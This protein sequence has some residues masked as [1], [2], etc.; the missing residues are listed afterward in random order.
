MEGGPT[1]SPRLALILKKLV[2]DRILCREALNL[3]HRQNKGWMGDDPKKCPWA[4][5][6][7]A[8]VHHPL[9]SFL[10]EIIQTTGLNRQELL[11]AVERGFS[12]AVRVVDTL[13]RC[14]ADGR[15]ARLVA[16]LHRL[17][18]DVT[19]RVFGWSTETQS[20]NAIELAS[21]VPGVLFNV[22][23]YEDGGRGGE[24]TCLPFTPKR[25]G[26]ALAPSQNF[27]GGEVDSPEESAELNGSNGEHAFSHNWEVLIDVFR[28][29]V[30][31]TKG[32]LVDKARGTPA[33]WPQAEFDAACAVTATQR[34]EIE[35]VAGKPANWL[36]DLLEDVQRAARL[37]EGECFAF[38]KSL[39]NYE[40]A[41]NRTRLQSRNVSVSEP[42]IQ[43]AAT[44]LEAL[45][46]GTT[47]KRRGRRKAAE[48]TVARE[49]QIAANWERARDAGIYK[50]VFARDNGMTTAKL[51]AL[52]DR[53]A[54][55][56]K[57][58]DK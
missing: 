27:P 26:S 23:V 22:D 53:V 3:K 40:F 33:E 15:T 4:A 57:R 2:H 9:R 58:S 55:R 49:A 47:P 12:D 13:N 7:D 44:E 39:E 6:Y 37:P 30:Q 18:P 54:K 36:N 29:V 38:A 45:P 5:E 56:N 41:L 14:D 19:H 20:N 43:E 32:F 11:D 51:D 1:D 10:T 42:T 17:F 46:A 28:D 16:E 25:T 48:Q 34:S 31:M 52:L 50:P 35:N 21:S 24:A 8:D